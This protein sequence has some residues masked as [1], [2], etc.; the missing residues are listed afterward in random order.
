MS[1]QE[2]TG[3]TDFFAG[4]KASA[5]TSNQSFDLIITFDD[6]DIVKDYSVI[7]SSF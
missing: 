5:S 6:K 2:K 4:Q 7:S 3:R 1:V